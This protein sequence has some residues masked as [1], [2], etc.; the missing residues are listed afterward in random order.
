MRLVRVRCSREAAQEFTARTHG[1]TPLFAC[2]DADSA[3]VLASL[4]DRLE[5]DVGVWLVVSPG[6]PAQIA[7]RDARTLSV[8]VNLAHVVID[9]PSEPDQH[10][11]IVRRLLSGDETT[12]AN[13]VARLDHVRSLPVPPRPLVVWSAGDGG[14]ASPGQFLRAGEPER[15][16]DL[17]L[18]YFE[19]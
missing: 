18:T 8:L 4:A 10:A 15:E 5:R 13:D 9:A 19:G 2:R 6:Y 11:E 1:P 14:L 16:G 3:I 12:F 7:T 17:E